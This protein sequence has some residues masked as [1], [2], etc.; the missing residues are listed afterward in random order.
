MNLQELQVRQHALT[1]EIRAKQVE[2]RALAMEINVAL[3]AEEIRRDF[4]RLR[5][6]HGADVL[7]RVAALGLDASGPVNGG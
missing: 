3:A 7:Q 4:E 5:D 6:R 2:A 1:E